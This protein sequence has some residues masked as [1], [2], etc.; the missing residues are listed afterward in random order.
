MLN[1]TK[2]WLDG[3]QLTTDRSRIIDNGTPLIGWTVNSSVAGDSQAACRVSVTHEADLLWDSGWVEQ[4]TQRITYAGAPLPACCPLQLQVAVRSTSGQMAISNVETFYNGRRPVWEGCWIAPGEDRPRAVV[5]YC[6]VFDLED[7][8]TDAV[9]YLAGI[10]YHKAYLNGFE[11]DTAVMDPAHT[12]YTK[13]VHYTVLPNLDL[14]L[15]P[16]ENVLVVQVA[17]G[18]R[19]IDSRFVDKNTKDAGREIEFDGRPMLTAVLEWTDPSGEKQQLVTDG[20]WQWSYGPITETNIFDGETYD[21]RVEEAVTC[22]PVV[23]VEGPGGELRPMTIP[24]ILEQETYPAIDIFEPAPGVFVADFGQ[25]IAGVLRFA[26]PRDLKPGQTITVSFMEFLDEDGTIYRAPLR[27]A[28]QTDTYIASGDGRDL[29]LWQPQFTYHGFRYAEIRGLDLVERDQL[30]AVALY[31]D[32]ASGSSFRCGDPLINKIHQN[33]VQT[34][35][36]NIHSILT[37]C[38]Q[39]DERMGWMNDATVRFE[40]TPYNFRIGRLFAK[41][42]RDILNEQRPNGAITCCAPFVFGALPADPVCSSFL[43]AGA[44]ALLHTGNLALIEEAFDG[45][46]AWEDFL[47]SQSKDY[48]VQY[49]YYGDWAGPAYAC[50]SMEYAISSTTPGILMSTGYSYFN[51]RTLATYARL[52]G[53]KA[54]EEK[55]TDLAAKV[56]AAFLQEWWHAENGTVAAGSQGAHAFALWLDILP[57]EGRTAAAKALRDDLVE[58]NYMFTTGNLCTRYMMDMLARYGYVEEAWTLLHKTDYPS[59]GFMIQNEA[60]TIWERFELKKDPGMNSHNH[61]MYG[62]VDMWFYRWLCGICPTAAGFD[63]VTIAPCYPTGLLSAQA[64]VDTVH[65]DVAVR[66]VRRYGQLHLYVRIPF[67]VSA[68]VQ[69]PEGP[70]SAGSGSH[71]YCWPLDEQ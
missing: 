41:V 36:A 25:N 27:E 56:R 66:W 21:A 11:L 18:W 10:G 7:V 9:L 62:A 58:K 60:T 14:Y 1:I 29:E 54:D 37:D 30:T 52:L 63:A 13:T 42:V 57:E 51:C 69:L 4:S 68:T 15:Q 38:P 28:K 40:E 26:L 70:V 16:G 35:K 61:P 65:G 19:R 8:P 5:E 3:G 39:R 55:Y 64:V 33:A 45:F 23:C 2:L 46:A 44:E 71:H 12:N 20:S 31:T 67:G 32:V 22:A 47:L 6:K 34:E 49:S 53:R 24:P 17:E 50:A 48:I 59:Y 43:V